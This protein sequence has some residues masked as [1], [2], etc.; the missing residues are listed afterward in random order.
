[1]QACDRCHLRKTRCDRRIPRCTACEKAGAQCLHVDKLRSRNLPRGYV[2]SLE[3]DLRKAEDENLRLQRELSVLHAQVSSATSKD[4]SP[5]PNYMTQDAEVEVSTDPSASANVGQNEHSNGANPVSQFPSQERNVVM[6]AASMAST[7]TPADEAFTTEV[8][9]LTLTAAG[10]TRYLGSS[11]GMGLAS[12]ISSVLDPQQS[13]GFCS[14][15]LDGGNWRMSSAASE[16]P[17]PPQNL[18][19]PFIEAYFQHTHLTFPLLHRPTFLAA[20]EQIYSNPTYYSTH[21]FDAFA[22]DMVLAIGSS[23]VN[24]FEEST[25]ITATHYT[26][27]QKKLHELL[28]MR[29]LV[30]LQTIILLSQHGIFSNLRDTSGSIWHLIGIGARMCFEL[31]LHLE[32]KRVDRQT[33]RPV[34]RTL[35]ITF[36]VEMRR[37]TFWCFYNLDRVVSFT[38]GR[39]VALRDEDIDISLPSHLEDEE[40]GPDQPI[41]PDSNPDAPKISPF[42]HVIKIRHLSG[43]ILSTLYAAKQ[44]SEIPLQ[45]KVRVRSQLYDELVAWKNAT[46]LLNLEDRHH[47][48]RAFVSC[49]LSVHWYNAVFNNAVLLLY[50]PSPYLPH[51][52]MPTKPGE[53]EGDLQRLYYAAKSSISSYYELHRRRQLNYSWI[54]LHGIFIDGLA[55]VYGIGLALRNPSHAMPTPDYL[56]IINDTRAC[57]NILVAICERWSVARSSCELF[58]RLS[59]AV[60]RDAVNAAAKKDLAPAASAQGHQSGRIYSLQGATTLDRPSPSASTAGDSLPDSWRLGS[61]HYDLL[62]SMNQ[63]DHMFVADEFRQYSNALDMPARG[64]QAVP[65]E[66]INGFSQDWP[67]EDAPLVSQD[68]FGIPMQGVDKLW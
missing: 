15:D 49:F 38:L 3:S 19:M 57:S 6:T 22:F 4:P 28:N 16:A 43:K 42:L 33:R 14:N 35:P 9:Y 20:V 62:S 50:R 13:E 39:P 45:E 5:N 68:A 65:S 60:I 44:K 64:D 32:L 66:L 11:S 2:E 10:E 40:F 61:D 52:V 51:P 67:F 26:R 36:E 48:N 23:N 59:N 7:R 54:T 17:F 55:Y 18:A 41:E 56:E 63:F 37:R 24:R 8:G 46:S 47:N 25:A 53:E 58:N 29:G 1:M 27:A 31:G 30:P 34:A 21:P 12:I